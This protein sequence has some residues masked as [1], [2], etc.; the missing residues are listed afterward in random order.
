MTTTDEGLLSLLVRR[1]TWEADGVL[2]VEL[3]HPD[4]KPLPGWAPGAHLDVHVGGQIRQYSLCGDPADTGRYRIGVLNEPSSRG[5]SRHVHTKLRPGQSVT[6]S[7]PRNHFAL[8]DAPAYVFVAGGIGVTPVLAMARE[9]ARRGDRWR[10]VYGGRSRSSMAFTDELAAL[11]GDLTLV[12]QD[13]LGHIDLAAELADLPEGALVYCCGPEPLLA[14]VEERCPADRLRLE[15]FAAPV[16][17]LSGDDA[18]F[19]VECRT[20][21]LTLSVDSGTS[22]LEAAEQAGLSVN[23]SCR[24]GICGSCETRVLDGT[25]DHRD[26]LLSEAEHAANASMMICVSRCASGRLVL[27]L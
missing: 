25:P 2:S 9:A 14:A 12:P 15:R 23:S 3:A 5:G 4:G 16:V 10:M 7:A 26:F 24:D 21:G 17:A 19:D 11:G 27:D 13:E 1:M 20:S 8:E 18:A 22:I 6:V